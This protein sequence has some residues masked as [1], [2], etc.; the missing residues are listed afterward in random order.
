MIKISALVSGRG[1]NLQAVIDA[2]N[3]G[4]IPNAQMGIVISNKEDAYALERAS[5]AN[6]KTAV[7]SKK[8][9]PDT[10]DFANE[11][12]RLLE[13]AETD[14][15]VLAGYMSILSL[16]VIRA[17][18]G[19]MI[20]IHPSLIPKHCGVGY[21]GSKVHESVLASGDKESG[22]TVHFVDDQEV[23]GGEIIIQKS[24]PVMPGDTPDDLA[25]RVLVI[26]HEILVEGINKVKNRI[27]E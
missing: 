14:I 20:N 12:L 16:K 13:E 9:F 4:N 25:A 18:K 3:N 23:D 1:T 27:A 5:Q 26:E 7:V 8:D 11:L 10:E 22:A 15:V 17:Y 6:I 19:R 21:Y 24:V 2:V